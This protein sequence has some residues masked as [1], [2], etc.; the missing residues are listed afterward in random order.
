MSG[1]GAAHGRVRIEDAPVFVVGAARS[2]T[3]LMVELLR[4]H[5][6]IYNSG[7]TGFYR[8]LKA[9]DKGR[10]DN[11]HADVAD[12][13]DAVAAPL[14]GRLGLDPT[15]ARRRFEELGEPT[16]LA[17]HQAILE[18]RAAALGKPRWGDKPLAFLRDVR[19]RLERHP[20]AR[21]VWMVRDPRA[22][23]ASRVHAPWD[24]TSFRKLIRHTAHMLEQAIL[25]ERNP[26]VHV[27]RYETLVKRP[28]DVLQRVFAFLG[29][30]YNPGLAERSGAGNLATR[31]SSFKD[32]IP[33][34]GPA[35]R[36]DTLDRWR[37][38]LTAAQ[39]AEIEVVSRA[40]MRHWGYRPV[41]S[42]PDRLRA[43]LD[44]LPR[45]LLLRS[46]PLRRWA[47]AKAAR[48]ARRR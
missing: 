9:F 13:W 46:K 18:T 33:V 41:S 39:I 36:D 3:T 14:C 34:H 35:I 29:E 1:E 17:M 45:R 23:A 12:A 47:R 43:E 31:H 21:V 26:R 40:G 15:A 32:S 37:T 27:V 11:P 7:E 8:A 42:L 16:A 4:A 19:A 38:A 25:F 24:T 2:G 10:G 6:R 20:Q 30:A 5:P 22:T 28:D 48:V 44:L